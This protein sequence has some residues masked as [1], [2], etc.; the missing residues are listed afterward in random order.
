MTAAPE[1]TMNRVIHGAVRRDLD[2]LSTALGQ[3]RD[4]DT[5]RAQAL[6]RAYANLRT[7]LTHHHEGEDTHIFPMLQRIGVD[8]GLLDAMESEHHAMADALTKTAGAMST[9]ARTGS[10]GDAAVAQASVVRTREVVERHL[11]H[12][13]E[14]LE[15]QLNAHLGSP[16]W[17]AVEKELRS[18]PLG[19][20][21][22][23]FAWL[24]DG[25][26][27]EHRA[28]LKKTVPTPVVTVL[29]RTFGRRYYKD[30]APTWR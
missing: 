5:A 22:R 20:A 4:G 9:V 29:A 2:R 23:F 1:M 28:F 8:Q 26:S 15:P 13:E 11:R 30:V 21:G 19:V 12:E 27:D 16:E 6:E 24:T 10:S 3:L 7:E 14:E 18:Q 17:K 25:M